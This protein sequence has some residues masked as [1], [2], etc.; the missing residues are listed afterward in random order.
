MQ[1]GSRLTHDAFTVSLAVTAV[2]RD[3]ILHG[4]EEREV[5]LG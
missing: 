5:L 3:T 4:T 2:V 1:K